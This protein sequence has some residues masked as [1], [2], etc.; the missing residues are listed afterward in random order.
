MKTLTLITNEMLCNTSST[1]NLANSS[2]QGCDSSVCITIIICAAILLLGILISV[3]LYIMRRKE[4]SAKIQEEKQIY[5]KKLIDFLELQA[6][7]K[8]D[9]PTAEECK[10][11]ISELKSLIQDLKPTQDP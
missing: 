1:T 4:N 5:R 9:T 3:M 11:Y 6:K 10:K 8:K 7:G 2:A